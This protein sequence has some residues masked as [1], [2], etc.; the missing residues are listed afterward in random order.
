MDSSLT[1]LHECAVSQVQ[2][3]HLQIII[4]NNNIAINIATCIVRDIAGIAIHVAM[5]LAIMIQTA[6]MSWAFQK[7]HRSFPGAHITVAHF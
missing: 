2:V 5:H 3:T 4:I 6:T 7:D 1:L